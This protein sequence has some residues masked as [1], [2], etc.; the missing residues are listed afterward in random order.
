LTPFTYL[1]VLWATAYGYAVFG[2]LPDGWSV[3]GMMVIVASG[4]LLALTYRR[5]AAR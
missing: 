3:V 1:Q 2:Q 5:R 4:M